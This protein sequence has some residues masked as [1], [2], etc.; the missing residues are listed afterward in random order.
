MKTIKFLIEKEF[1]QMFRNPLIPRMIVAYPIM[2]ILVFPW[3]ISFEIKNIK[4]D[5]VDHN[6]STYSRRLT[7]KIEASRYFILNATPPDYQTAMQNMESGETD[8]IMEIPSSF[9]K[10][11]IKN[12]TSGVGMAV[13]SV[14]GTQ[15]LLGSNYIMQIVNDFSSELRGELMHTLPLKTRAS[16]IKMPKI[17]ILQQYKFN[18]A[19]DYKNFMIPGFMVLLLTLICGI[20]PALNIVMEKENGTINQINVTPV[21][22]IVFILAKLIPFWIVGLVVMIISVSAA[23]LLYGLWP[24][25]N[26][27]AVLLSAIVFIISI[28]GLGIIISNYSET[29]QQASFLVM[30]FILILILL[31][32]MFTPISSMPT[33]AQTI[34]Y[35]NPFTYLTNT[36]RMLYLNGSSLADVSGNLMNLGII[37][38][39]LNGWAVISYKKRG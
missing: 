10:E 35:I 17:E 25:G 28:S 23:Y 5:V 16:M 6:K 18:P 33:W 38:V 8:M 12:R 29:M 27:I 21:N 19:L 3:A 7:E 36:F 1:K 2:V 32:G 37:A 31:G 14:N 24:T 26:I 11:L 22:R 13:N 34:A 15:G 9:D 39:V 4:I 20:L 30:F